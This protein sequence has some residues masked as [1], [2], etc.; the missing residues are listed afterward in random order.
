MVVVEGGE[1]SSRAQTLVRPTVGRPLTDSTHTKTTRP[2]KTHQKSSHRSIT[3]GETNVSV[4]RPNTAQPAGLFLAWM[5][6][7]LDF[8]SGC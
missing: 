6:C 1:P 7:A 8:W 4:I 5:R 2:Q 3:Q